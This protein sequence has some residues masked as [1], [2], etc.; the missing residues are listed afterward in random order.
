MQYLT[1]EKAICKI[2]EF[3]RRRSP[4][5]FVIDFSTRH[6]V[7]LSKKKAD[8]LGIVF[9]FSEQRRNKKHL[10]AIPSFSFDLQPIPFYEYEHAFNRIVYHLNRGDTYLLN[11]TFP[12]KISTSADISEI[13]AVSQAPYKLLF[14]NRFVSFSPELFIRINAGRIFSCPM[15]GTIDASIPNAEEV[16]LSDAKE[17]F[18]HNTIVDLIRNDLAMVSTNVTV[19]RF[20]YIDRIRTSRRDLLQVSSEIMGYL[21]NDYLE[22]LGNIIFTL[23]PAGSVTGAPKERTVQIINSVET[24]DRGFYTGIFGYFDGLNLES[25]VTIR[26]IE[27]INGE[28]YYR[29]GGGLTAHSDVKKEYEELIQKVYVPIV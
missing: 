11:L 27:S 21:P 12:T 1:K 10:A 20:R 9:S 14:Q 6:S 16:I 4:F 17:T 19:N 18:E 25:A 15:K 3:A 24:S 28:L 8:D 13:F 7:V 2:N 29:S 26:F 22:N 5:F 23:L